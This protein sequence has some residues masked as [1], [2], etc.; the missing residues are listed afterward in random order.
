LHS[1]V[2]GTVTVK[3]EKFVVD[4]EHLPL[5]R[6]R[7]EAQLKEIEKAERAVEEHRREREE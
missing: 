1:I 5:L 4:A 7:L 3:E 2:V 6:E